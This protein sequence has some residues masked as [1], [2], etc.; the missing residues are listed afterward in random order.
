[1]DILEYVEQRRRELEKKK[2]ESNKPIIQVLKEPRNERISM[3]VTKSEKEF[4]NK[5]ASESDVTITELFLNLI[6]DHYK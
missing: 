6:M 5:I 2:L 4:I 3:R 1:M